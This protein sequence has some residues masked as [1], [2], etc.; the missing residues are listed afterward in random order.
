MGD[1]ASKWE[2]FGWQSLEVDGHDVAA[3]LEALQ[4]PHDKPL[5]IIA[6]TVKGKGV[7]FMEH[8]RLWH[9]SRLTQAQ[10][11]QAMAEQ[12]ACDQVEGR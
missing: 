5:A 4:A 9:Y 12:S 8:N 6:H 10:F 7:S 1:L 2:S 3:L 11:E